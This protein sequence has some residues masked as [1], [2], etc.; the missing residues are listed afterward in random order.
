VMPTVICGYSKTDILTTYEMEEIESSKVHFFQGDQLFFLPERLSSGKRINV[1]SPSDIIGRLLNHSAKYTRKEKIEIRELL[2]ETAAFTA[3]IRETF[4]NDDIDS[5]KRSV[6]AFFRDFDSCQEIKS[7]VDQLIVSH[8][9]IREEIEKAKKQEADQ[10][11]EQYLEQQRQRLDESFVGKRKEVHELDVEVTRLSKTKKQLEDDLSALKTSAGEAIATLKSEYEVYVKKGPQWKADIHKVFKQ[12]G[13]FVVTPDPPDPPDPGTNSA[14]SPETSSKRIET[15]KELTSIL[16]AEM[17]MSGADVKLLFDML[18]TRFWQLKFSN[19]E[20]M[21]K[22]VSLV[23]A[24]GLDCRVA[25]VD[26]DVSVL[27]P[28]LFLDRYCMLGSYQPCT[29]AE[30]LHQCHREQDG[31]CLLCVFAAN[32]A[33]IEGYL[34][35]L[36]T[37]MKISQ[38]IVYKGTALWPPTGLRIALQIDQDDYSAKPSNWLL[39]TF[40]PLD[41]PSFTLPSNKFAV[42]PK[43]LTG[44]LQ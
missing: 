9:I 14:L 19:F 39:N 25:A 16:T 43:I 34:T 15:L 36:I 38:P 35:P 3:L 21:A 8:P 33:P 42:D 12:L 13:H 40:Q 23:G 1:L 20:E 22:L 26:I 37:S 4:P 18:R 30:F 7:E 2:S 29:V 5:I 6:Q 32:R 41:L 28:S 10:Y 27:T 24:L 44:G 11:A 31:W 17:Q